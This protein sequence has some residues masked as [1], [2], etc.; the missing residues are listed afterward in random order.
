MSWVSVALLVL[1]TQ[2][3]AP[4]AAPAAPQPDPQAPVVRE[5]VEVVG[6]TPVHGL[7]VPISMV[8]ANVQ[9]LT[10]GDMDRRPGASFGELLASRLASVHLNETQNNPFQPDVQF[11]GFTASPLLGLP[12]GVAVYLDGVRAN[13][14][15]GDTMNWDLVP[16]N[17]IASVNVVPGS[18]PLFG[19]NALGGA[20]SLQ[21][22]TGFSHPGHTVRAFGGWF[23]RHW[24]E[25]ASGGHSGNVSYFASANALTED[26]WRD[27]SP[28]R[29]GQFFGN[30][31][32]RDGTSSLGVSVAGGLGRLVGNGPAPVDLL[33]IDR[34]AIFTHPDRT[35]SRA[36]LVS[37]RGSRTLSGG[38]LEGV[39]YVRPAKIGTFNGDDTTYDECE[40]EQFDE[41]LCEDD[42]E[43]DPVRTPDGGPD[44]G[45]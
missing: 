27:F 15:F 17:A 3:P 2:T 35:T 19:L 28:S 32:W 39:I 6:V 23:G 5:Q 30:V 4:P 33:D 26:G 12:Q 7:G 45:R 24:L 38:S 41:L 10:A 13:E 1:Q 18:N 44:S 21:T 16:Q 31:E 8:P 34:R 37:L 20:L 42:G 14:P 11:R 25:F 29:L 9:I 40:D 43:G 22:K 36:A